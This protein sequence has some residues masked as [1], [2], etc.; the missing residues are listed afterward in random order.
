YIIKLIED[1]FM[2]KLAGNTL[3]KEYFHQVLH[4]LD[5]EL[6]ELYE[7]SI[8]LKQ[9]MS[10][11]YVTVREIINIIWDDECGGNSL[12]GSGRGS[13]AGF[14]I[15]FLLGIT[16]INPL[17]YGVELP[18]WRHLHRSRPDIADIDIDT[19]GSKR[20]QILQALRN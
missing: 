17:V 10:S 9:A 5:L 18:H 12:V 6:G 1:G 3:S 19:E 2:E 16:Q 14:L 8:K 13:A 20:P 15:N 4:R 11:Y 7:I